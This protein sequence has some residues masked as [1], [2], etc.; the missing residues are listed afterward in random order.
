M[1]FEIEVS[2]GMMAEIIRI[3]DNESLKNVL[4]HRRELVRIYEPIIAK[5]INAYEKGKEGK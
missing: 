4:E 5:C 3:H 2:D 1:K